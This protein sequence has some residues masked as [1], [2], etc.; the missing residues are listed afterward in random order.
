V[1]FFNLEV[2]VETLRQGSRALPVKL[3]QRL[4]NKKGANPRLGEDG[5]FGPKT[6]AGVLAFQARGR[7][8]QDGVVGTATWARLGLT[9]DITHSMQLVP[10]PT[11]MTCW[12]AAATMIVG[13]MSVGPGGARISSTGGLLPSLANV[14]RFAQ[15][16]GWVLYGP[17]T[18][19]VRGLAALLSRRPLWAVGGWI[20][21]G[22]RVAPRDR[23]ECPVER[24]SRRCQRYCTP[25]P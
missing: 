3:L 8:A 12:T 2:H 16:L 5:I 10:Q 4:L 14:Q 25:D 20:E 23:A 9:V 15:S 19:T 18:W 6:R 7:I 21:P 1:R 22:R 24:W 17:Q 13:N 11:N